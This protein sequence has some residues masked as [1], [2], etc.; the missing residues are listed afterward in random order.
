M[1]ESQI[2][3]APEGVRLRNGKVPNVLSGRVFL[4]ETRFYVD[5]LSSTEHGP[6]LRKN[7]GMNFDPINIIDNT[8]RIIFS[9]GLEGKG[10]HYRVSLTE[11]GDTSSPLEIFLKIAKDDDEGKGVS[12][13]ERMSFGKSMTYQA[14]QLEY[15]NSLGITA[16]R[17]L[18]LKNI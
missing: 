2:L 6:F 14:M 18:E 1:G 7:Y 4:P 12:H 17:F 9:S 11:V 5:S 3:I 13:R 15:W 10:R 16:P 8:P